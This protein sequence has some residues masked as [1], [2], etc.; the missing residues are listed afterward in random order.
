MARNLTR[1]ERIR[2]R[3]LLQELSENARSVRNALDPAHGMLAV[4]D[5]AWRD[6]WLALTRDLD[7]FTGR[8]I[9]GKPAAGGVP[10]RNK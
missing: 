6:Q 4:T 7:A 1:T 9:S 10:D 2:A 3:H 8:V 5:E